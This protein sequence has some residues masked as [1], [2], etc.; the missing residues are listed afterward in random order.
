MK[1]HPSAIFR[2]WR[3]VHDY[4]KIMELPNVKLI[5]YS[6]HSTDLIKKSSLIITISSTA[7]FEAAFYNK[8]SIILADMDYSILPSVHKI[9]TID[10]V[11]YTHLTLPT[12][13]EV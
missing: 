5:H 12:N 1:E 4:K 6:V 3:P 11:S 7:G 13:R 2:E 9:K 8:P 10:A